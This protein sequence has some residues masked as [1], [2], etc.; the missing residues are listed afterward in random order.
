M[1]PVIDK[2][3]CVDCG[4]CAQICPLDVIRYEKDENGKKHVVVKYPYECRAWVFGERLVSGP[5]PG[6][7]CACWRADR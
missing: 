7:P 6:H 2:E 3:K 4:T 5:L 1:P